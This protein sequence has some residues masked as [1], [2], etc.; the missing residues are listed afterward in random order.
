MGA[1]LFELDADPDRCVSSPDCGLEAWGIE[2]AVEDELEVPPFR[3]VP[4]V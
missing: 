4:R 1:E 2:D 3:A